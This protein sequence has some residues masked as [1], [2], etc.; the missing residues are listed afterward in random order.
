MSIEPLP[1][2]DSSLGPLLQTVSLLSPEI[3]QDLLS[4]ATRIDFTTRPASLAVKEVWEKPVAMLYV[5][6]STMETTGLLRRSV[7]HLTTGMAQTHQTILERTELLNKKQLRS[8]QRANLE[9][10]LAW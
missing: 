5:P 2:L 3:K 4:A 8:R 10:V 7:Q 1:D 9:R 6:Q